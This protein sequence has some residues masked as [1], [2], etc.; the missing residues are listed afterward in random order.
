MIWFEGL[1]KTCWRSDWISCIYVNNFCKQ[2]VQ[3]SVRRP[4]NRTFLR[5]HGEGDTWTT[6]GGGGREGE[7]ERKRIERGKWG[8]ES[9]REREGE[10]DV[11]PTQFLI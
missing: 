4:G 5:E 10:G 3:V 6:E 2:V 9:E 11:V 1:V 7:R 8:R